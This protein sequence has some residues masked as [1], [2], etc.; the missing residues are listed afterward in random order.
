MNGKVHPVAALF[1]M[2]TGSDLESLAEDI[3][4]NGLQNPIVMQGDVL[5]D[6]RNRMAACELAGVEP[7]RVQYAGEDARAFIISSNLHRRHL[8][9]S[10]RAM[11]AARMANMRQGER[12]DLEPSANSHDVSLQESADLL[13]VGRHTVADAKMIEREAPDLAER[14]MAGELTVHAAKEQVRPHVAQN[15]GENEWYT[16][17]EYIEA[18]RKVMG[19]IDLD[20][21]STE[22]ANTVVKA[23][24][25]YTKEDDGLAQPW[26]GRVW[27]NPPYA[28]P[29]VR[30]FCAKLMDDVDA[31]NVDQAIVLVNNAT[32]TEWFSMLIARASVVCFPDG[33]VKFWGPDGRVATPLQGQAV[34]YIG[35]RVAEFRE[36][37]ASFGWGGEPWPSL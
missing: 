5:L 3:R 14:V 11:I 15:S 21:A 31:G 9:E 26:S 1:P 23:A 7:L 37:F 29:I 32:E 10:Q 25:F 33:R 12:T 19:G 8:S 4:A 6:G 34:L 36:A 18:A 13:N 2:L 22:E 24:K 30:Y 17:A 20:P 28:Q 16:P 35:P 27:L